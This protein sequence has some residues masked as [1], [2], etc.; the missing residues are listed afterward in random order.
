MNPA[1]RGA[2]RTNPTL[3]MQSMR[4]PYRGDSSSQ[5]IRVAQ[6]TD[7]PY[8]VTLRVIGPPGEWAMFSFDPTEL[9]TGTSLI[10]L[11]GTFVVMSG[12]DH[13]MRL[14]PYQV[15]YAKGSSTGGDGV[16]PVCVSVSMTEEA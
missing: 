16:F 2:G 12:Q 10:P 13:T 5:A 11:G 8:E 14:L 1:W 6:A 3:T 9:N 15:I 7:K 4:L